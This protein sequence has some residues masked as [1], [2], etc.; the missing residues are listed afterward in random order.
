ML[1][2]PKE[3]TPYNRL[4]IIEKLTKELERLDLS[5]QVGSIKYNKSNFSYL[6]YMANIKLLNE[7]RNELINQEFLSLSKPQNKVSGIDL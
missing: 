6:S 4:Y 3:F 1:F 2:K 5:N 7:Y